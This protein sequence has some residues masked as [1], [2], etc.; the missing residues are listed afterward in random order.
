MTPN[1]NPNAAP[2][3][4]RGVTSDITRQNRQG[5]ARGVERARQAQEVEREAAAQEARASNRE[6]TDKIDLSSAARTYG[7]ARS[8]RAESSQARTE[9]IAALAAAHQDGSLNNSE[10]IEAAARNMLQGE[11][12]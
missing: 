4:R 5:I 9:R 12:L 7:E 11:D 6:E 2:D 1:I 10:R 3:P 8:S